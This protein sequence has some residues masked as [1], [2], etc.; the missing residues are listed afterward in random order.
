MFN[1]IANLAKTKTNQSKQ[2]RKQQTPNP[3]HNNSNTKHPTITA[4]PTQLIKTQPQ[5]I[6]KPKTHYKQS[7]QNQNVNPNIKT[8][9]LNIDQTKNKPTQNK[10]THEALL[11]KKI[12]PKP[13]TNRSLGS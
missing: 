4:K 2:T 3:F 12:R 6:T 10:Q 1:Q 9:N 13:E 8:P 5:Q 7:T 11:N